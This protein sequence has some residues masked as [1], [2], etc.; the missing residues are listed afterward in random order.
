METEEDGWKKLRQ[1]AQSSV[2]YL[3][4]GNHPPFYTFSYHSYRCS[5]NHCPWFHCNL[6]RYHSFPRYVSFSLQPFLRHVFYATLFDDSETKPGRN[7]NRE[8]RI[9]FKLN[10][11]SSLQIAKVIKTIMRI[12]REGWLGCGMEWQRIP[13]PPFAFQLIT[14]KMSE[15][16][17]DASK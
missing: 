5:P 15:L 7:R 1:S 9:N 3:S 13:N 2:E 6:H 8:K 10:L 11:M 14:G 16:I 4:S 17:K 12:I